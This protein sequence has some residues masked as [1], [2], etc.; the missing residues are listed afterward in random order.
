MIL[1]LLL[2]AALLVGG[3]FLLHMT[4]L[5]LPRCKSAAKLHGKTAIVTGANTGI[6]K[7]TAMDLARRGARVILACRDRRRAEAAAQEIIQETGNSQ[8]IFMQLDLASLK[9]VRSFA[10][11][12]LRSESRLDLLINNAGLM[13]GGKTEDGFGMIFGV[14]HLG[15]FLLTVLLLERLKASGRSR[16]VTVASKAYEMGKVDFNCLTTHRDVALGDGDLQL[17]HKYCHSKLCNV[18]FTYELAKR[19]QGSDVTCY[20]LHPGAIQTEIGRYAGFWWSLMMKPIVLLFFVDAESGAQTTLHCALEPGIEHASGQYFSCC[21]P[22]LNIESK[23][24]DDAAAK[25]L[26]ELSESFCGLA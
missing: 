12:F 26:W 11:E 17:F 14:N 8:V 7:T 22:K 21:A 23:A 18:L 10:D 6:G 1:E 15:H 2:F 4:F 13:N 24:T 25:K 20:S 9:S 19:L 16:V 3:Y 5:K